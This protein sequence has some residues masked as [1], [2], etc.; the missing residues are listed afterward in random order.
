MSDLNV[1]TIQNNNI[2]K[3]D[4]LLAFNNNDSKAASIQDVVQLVPGVMAIGVCDTAA[5][6]SAKVVTCEDWNNKPEQSILVTFTYANTASN[7]TL[8]INGKGALPIYNG[9]T[10]EEYIP[11]GNMLFIV[12][13]DCTKLQVVN[14]P[15]AKQTGLTYKTARWLR[16]SPTNKKSLV[17]K[18]GT[19]IKVGSHIY[20]AVKD[21]TYS[22]GSSLTAGTEYFVYL[23][24]SSGSWTV[25]CSTTH[26]A[27]TATSRY[28]GRFHTLCAAVTTD[29]VDNMLIPASPNSGLSAGGNILVKSYDSLKDSDFYNLYNKTIVSVETGTYYNVVTCSHILAGYSAGDILPESV[30]C[31]SFGVNTLHKDAMVYDKDT[32]MFIDVYL[33]SGTGLNTKSVYN[34]THTARRAGTCHQEDMRQ[35]GKKLL[36]DDVFCSAA[37][38]GNECT[39]I[40]GSSDKMTVGGHVDTAGKRMVSAIGCEEMTG[41]LWQ[42]LDEFPYCNTESGWQTIDNQG[43]FGQQYWNTHQLLAGGAW[44]DGSN[45]GSRCRG[46][47]SGRADVYAGIG[48][49]GSSRAVYGVL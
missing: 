27:D 38:G 4:K 49:R 45:C 43:S 15:T 16:F 22:M 26:T 46:S 29:A 10:R 19:S 20:N 5:N 37:I 24:Y 42:W 11:E 13:S 28:I 30:M 6:V 47:D 2:A 7:P 3:T 18:E 48:S 31:L 1:T 9:S 34:A 41:Y 36:N 12:N 40:T 17:I 8:N 25:T 33:Q 21:T 44:G 23:N 14:E 35:V 32:D 39:S